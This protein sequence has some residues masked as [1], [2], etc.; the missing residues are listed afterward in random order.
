MKE[1]WIK[2]Y[3]SS[4]EY[5]AVLIKELLERHDL[6]PVL[7]DRKDDEFLLGDAEIYVSTEEVSKAR[8]AIEDN[9]A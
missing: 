4:E 2:V 8:A 6:H 7:M 9:Q 1:G 5:Q 3:N